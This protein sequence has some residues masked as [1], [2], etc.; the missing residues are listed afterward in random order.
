MS[1]AEGHEVGSS[2]PSPLAQ[3]DA[4]IGQ[5]GGGSQYEAWSAGLAGQSEH[6]LL[7]ELTRMRSMALALRQQ[8]V[9]QQARTSAVFGTILATQAGGNL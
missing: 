9:E 2:A 3:L 6:G 8:L 1:I 5:Y 4:L 7:I